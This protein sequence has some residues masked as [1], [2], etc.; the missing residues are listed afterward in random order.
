MHVDPKK[1]PRFEVFHSSHNAQ[2][3][4]WHG[5]AIL[6]GLDLLEVPNNRKPNLVSA[7]TGEG[8]EDIEDTL[9]NSQGDGDRLL[10]RSNWLPAVARPNLRDVRVAARPRHTSSR[11][12]VNANLARSGWS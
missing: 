4:L 3:P 9:R 1:T 12:Q 5:T 10:T 7:G 11:N 8:I 6:F 2:V